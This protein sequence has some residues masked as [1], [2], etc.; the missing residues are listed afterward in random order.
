MSLR[1]DGVV[2][3]SLRRAHLAPAV[4]L[5][6][7]WKKEDDNPA[8]RSALDTCPQLCQSAALTHPR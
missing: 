7:V 5:Y 4:E 3:R 6:M 8:R 1:F 2:C